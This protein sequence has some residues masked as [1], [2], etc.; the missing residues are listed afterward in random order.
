MAHKAAK[1]TGHISPNTRPKYLGIKRF[2]GEKVAPGEI[3]VRQRGSR[4]LPGE[5]V[6][7]GRDFSLYA[8]KAGVVKFKTKK[9]GSFSGR[10]RK[11]TII[12]IN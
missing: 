5:N 10:R 8:I 11:K 6:R 9:I 2:D 7:L 12:A 3:L 4:Y 1:K